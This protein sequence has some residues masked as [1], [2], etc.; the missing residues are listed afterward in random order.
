[1]ITKVANQRLILPHVSWTKVLASPEINTS[2]YCIDAGELIHTINARMTSFINCDIV[3]SYLDRF[4]NYQRRNKTFKR[5][6]R[7]AFAVLM[8]AATEL[9]LSQK[10][11]K[12]LGI[13]FPMKPS[14]IP[15]R[16]CGKPLS[17][18]APRQLIE[19]LE[20][21]GLIDKCEGSSYKSERSA[22][23]AEEGRLDNLNRHTLV[24]LGSELWE[25]AK[26]V[27]Q[28]SYSVHCN[29]SDELVILKAENRS[30]IDYTDTPETINSRELL[31]CL[32]NIN[33]QHEW[34]YLEGRNIKELP[35]DSLN[36]RRVFSKGSLKMHGRIYSQANGLRRELKTSITIDGQPTVE[37]DY[38]AMSLCMAYGRAGQIPPAGDLY[39]I[40][41][42]PRDDVKEAVTRMLSCSSENES[43][44][45]LLDAASTK[46][47]RLRAKATITAVKEK[48]SAL[49]HLF[50]SGLAND[51]MY[52]ESQILMVIIGRTNRLMTPILPCHDG[53]YCRTSDVRQVKDA[54]T[55]AFFA[56]CRFQPIIKE[57]Q[58]VSAI[59]YA[60]AKERHQMECHL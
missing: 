21:E 8:L 16:Y 50:F 18:R 17:A 46:E 38:S 4:N 23:S 10:G 27:T 19:L 9:A 40:Q 59:S 3:K 60:T 44:N 28:L 22:F 42:F 45:S 51:L 55:H 11:Q 15:P 53:I 56:V 36:Y 39:D 20:Q 58:S 25:L 1:M 14:N 52:R 24:I 5:N 7:E 2:N 47:C 29:D 37:L 6:L 33:S 26:K 32:N 35:T 49:R 48:H 54:M 43:V 41:G 57:K 12:H 30:L 13:I 34:H 31:N